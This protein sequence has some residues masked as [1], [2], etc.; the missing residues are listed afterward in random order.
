MGGTDHYTKNQVQTPGP[1]FQG[2][3]GRFMSS[4]VELWVSHFLSP[5]QFLSVSVKNKRKLNK[6]TKAMEEKWPPPM[7][8]ANPDNNKN[9]LINKAEVREEEQW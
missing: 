4:G 9:K 5:Y 2:V 8:S 1:N 6:Q 3:G 7:T